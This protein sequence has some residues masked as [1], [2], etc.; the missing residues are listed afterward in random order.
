MRGQLRSRGGGNLPLTGG[1]HLSAIKGGYS[2]W[3]PC[4]RQW[5]LR[6]G[7]LVKTTGESFR[8][9]EIK[10]KTVMKNPSI[11]V[12]KVRNVGL[13]AHTHMYLYMYVSIILGFFLK[14][15]IQAHPERWA[16]ALGSLLLNFFSAQIDIFELVSMQFIFFAGVGLLFE[17][18]VGSLGM[19]FGLGRD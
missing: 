10:K 15:R 4:R 13:N 6:E 2:H 7:W 16:L 9:K 14:K 3:Q 17:L 11:P 1:R 18:F 19:D 12:C 5:A 8:P